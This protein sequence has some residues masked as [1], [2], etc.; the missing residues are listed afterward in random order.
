MSTHR[1]HR[2]HRH[3]RHR[4]NQFATARIHR[5]RIRVVRFVIAPP[6]QRYLALLLDDQSHTRLGSLR[7]TGWGET[8]SEALEALVFSCAG[9][10]SLSEWEHTNLTHAW[11]DVYDAALDRE[12]AQHAGPSGEGGAR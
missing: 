6:G 1:A 5:F 2:A 8:E 12:E 9:H 7:A 10:T 11:A 4:H 3:N